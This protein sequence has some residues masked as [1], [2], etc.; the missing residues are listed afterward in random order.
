MYKFTIEL[1]NLFQLK[2]QFIVSNIYKQI[3]K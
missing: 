2:L 3:K 1:R